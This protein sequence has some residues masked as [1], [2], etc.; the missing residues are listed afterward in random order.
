MCLSIMSL[1]FKHC[2]AGSDFGM[3]CML[4]PSSVILFN[5]STFQTTTASKQL[6]PSCQGQI[7]LP[8]LCFLT[9][10]FL[11]YALL[12]SSGNSQH[13]WQ[14][15]KFSI[16]ILHIRHL[17]QTAEQPAIMSRSVLSVLVKDG[18]YRC[19]T[20]TCGGRVERH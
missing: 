11:F 3:L 4:Y 16:F 18:D 5:N 13:Y 19:F 9:R 14:S 8:S 1:L 7:R 10:F 2:R 12:S 20:S 6:P 17:A 15:F